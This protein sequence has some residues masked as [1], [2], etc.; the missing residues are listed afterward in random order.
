M[1]ITDLRREKGSFG[2]RLA[3]TVRWEDSKRTPVE[4][5]W[6]VDGELAESARPEPNAFLAATF[7]PAI[8]H[9]EHRVAIDGAVCPI[10]GA[11][12]RGI[13]GL[14]HSWYPSPAPIPA[15]EPRDGW[16]APMPRPEG[17]VAGYLTG[18]VDSL[19]LLHANREDFPANHPLRISHAFWIRG[20][21]YP[22]EEESS[23]AR[24]AYARLDGAVSENASD[25]GVRVVRITTNL[26]RMEP[27]LSFFAHWYL[28][29][30]LLSGAHLLAARFSTVALGS[31]WPAEHLV[32]WGTH[33]LLDVG[34]GSAAMSVRHEA[35]GVS[36]I[37]KLA[38]LRGQPRSLERLITCSD[39]PG[40]GSMNC[41]RCA[42]CVR[43]LLE[44][45]ASG[46]I[47]HAHS[48]PPGPVTP[49]AIDGLELDNGTEY[50]WGLLVAPLRTLGRE[51]IASAIER[52]IR[53][54]VRHRR[55]VEGRDWTGGIRR[56]DHAFLG[57]G[58]KKLY[59]TLRP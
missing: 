58:L 41:G 51:S 8:R 54:T 56:F 50:F 4:L 17:G 1:R 13:A 48:F 36:R 40:A 43:T 11:G 30:A 49:A 20:L 3:G 45:E 18:G 29:G 7:V 52:K 5:W 34:Y 59:R 25:A 6:D 9:G 24:S 55:R 10:L 33:P 12:L 15:V 22:G 14:L 39:A 32:P 28:G 46:T 2:A 47:A 23:H 38:R 27:D 16:V 53:E 31:S 44:M 19:H 42:K 37:E 35:L 57:G 21:D 26:R